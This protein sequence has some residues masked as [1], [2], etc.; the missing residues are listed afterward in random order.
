M[1]PCPKCGYV[2]EPEA[3][4]V[5]GAFLVAFKAMPAR[6]PSHNRIAALKAWKARVRSGINPEAMLAGAERYARYCQATGKVG[7]EFVKQA[8]TFFGPDRWWEQAWEIPAAKGTGVRKY[9]L[10]SG[11]TLVI[12]AWRVPKIV[13]HESATGAI[14]RYVSPDGKLHLLTGGR[15]LA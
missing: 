7:T 10:P 8:S 12:E 6:V 11:R 5:P 9:V 14:E 1:K 2:R 3:A 4:E 15:W 13:W